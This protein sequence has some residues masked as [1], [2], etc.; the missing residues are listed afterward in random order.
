MS[1]TLGVAPVSVREQERTTPRR[2]WRV[3][4]LLA[5]GIVY[6]LLYVVANDLVAATLSDGYSRM[7]QTVSELSAIDAPART[8]LIVLLLVWTGLMVAFGI[9][10][11]LV[12]DGNRALHVTG[13]VLVAFGIVGLLWL[14]FPMTS[15]QDMVEGTTPA[16]DV[17]HIVLTAATVILIVSMLGFGAAAF[18]KWFRLY[19]LVTAAIVLVFGGLTGMESPKVPEGE[20]TPWIGLVERISIGAWLLWM[21]VLAVLL[22]RDRS[23]PLDANITS[24]TEVPHR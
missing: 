9:G 3:R 8:F 20:P 14:A 10:V 19:S 6:A 18:G 2:A 17:G 12:S 4:V 13:G 7:S 5:C 1:A 11:R 15:R 16:N 24:A 23:D 21:V 22:L